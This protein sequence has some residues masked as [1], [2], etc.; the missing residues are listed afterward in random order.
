M[1][2]INNV[3]SSLNERQVGIQT[4]EEDEKNYIKRNQNEKKFQE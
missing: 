4:E 3:Q 2:A 1:D